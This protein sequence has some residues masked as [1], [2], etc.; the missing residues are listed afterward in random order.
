MKF[1][2]WMLGLLVTGSS[3]ALAQSG[4]N[5]PSSDQY[6]PQLADIMN[7]AQL[8]HQKLYLAGEAR[9]WPL[10]AFESRQ[11]RNSLA[12]AAVL[13]SGI[14]VSNVTTLASKLEAVNNAIAAKNGKGFTE[15]FAEL[16]GGCNECHRSM[17]RPFIVMRQPTDHPF[18]NQQFLPKGE[19]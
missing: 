9:N 8:K 14:P 15:A 6:V 5:V 13:Y 11:L 16:T 7:A 2:G 10:A 1:R 3:M 19:P 17:G 4:F 12:E 18:G